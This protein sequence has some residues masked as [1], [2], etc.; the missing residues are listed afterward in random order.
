ML[1]L[2]A[3]ISISRISAGCFTHRHGT[4]HTPTQKSKAASVERHRCT[5]IRIDHRCCGVSNRRMLESTND[6]TI[7]RNPSRFRNTK[8]ASNL[9]RLRAM[10]DDNNNNG[11]TNHVVDGRTAVQNS[12]T[13]TAATRVTTANDPSD[14]FDWDTFLDTPFFDP[15]TILQNPDQYHPILQ[16]IALWVQNDYEFVE[17][18][19]TGIFF[20]ILIVITQELLRIQIYGFENYVPFTKGV[21]PGSLF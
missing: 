13:V 14:T 21:N 5:Q 4:R 1:I 6:K 18:I 11:T 3:V 19:V 16:Q 2:V 12:T 8:L 17:A 15:A 7:E 10:N 20:I 9:W